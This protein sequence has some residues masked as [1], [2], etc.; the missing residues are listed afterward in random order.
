MTLLKPFER[1][2]A[3]DERALVDFLSDPGLLVKGTD[4]GPWPEYRG[5]CLSWVMLA[6]AP[7]LYFV[8]PQLG[9]DPPLV[10]GGTL[11]LVILSTLGFMR[12]FRAVR[13]A[14]RLTSSEL[15]WHALAWTSESLC[16]R[17]LGLCA[18]VQWS[19]VNDLRHFLPD[20]GGALDD[21]LWIHL[22]GGERLLVETRE[23]FFAGRRLSE[24]Y[25]DL[26]AQWGK[27]TGR[28]PAGDEQEP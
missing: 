6:L 10:R 24:W 17:S 27:K 13:R 28:S 1:L 11:V 20:E 18:I 21:T 3:D 19:E 9:V 7:V 22:D 4:K 23:G 12:S 8:A 5:G 16:F 14:R 26:R 25:T 2:S 15:G